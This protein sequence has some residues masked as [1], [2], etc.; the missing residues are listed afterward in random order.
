L[1][2]GNWELGIGNWELGIGNWGTPPSPPPRGE[3][4]I[5]ER[6]FSSPSSLL[7]LLLSPYLLFIS[8]DAIAKIFHSQLQ[9]LIQGNSRLPP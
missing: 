7:T 8:L 2:I 9:T 3:L 4:G 6:P 1:G 5:G